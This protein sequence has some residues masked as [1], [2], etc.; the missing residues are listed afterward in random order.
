MLGSDA[1][2]E[3]EEVVVEVVVEVEAV[4]SAINSDILTNS[5][6]IKNRLKF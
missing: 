1:V 2:V 3:S 6:Y 5:G 4:K